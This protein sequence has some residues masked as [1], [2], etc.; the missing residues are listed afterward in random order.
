MTNIELKPGTLKNDHYAS[1]LYR[2]NVNYRLQSQPKLEKISSFIL[3][4]EPF[5]EGR[6]KEVMGE[7]NLFQ[8]E[9]LMYTKVLPKIEKV[10][11]RYGDQT[12]LGPK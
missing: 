11:R 3:K 8:T 12:I 7:L 1:V 2:A 6:K 10:L 5:V 9:I 4:V